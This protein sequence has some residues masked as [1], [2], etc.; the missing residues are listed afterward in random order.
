MHLIPLS[1]AA[2]F[3]VLV[4]VFVALFKKLASRKAAPGIGSDLE[5]LFSVERYKPMDRLLNQTDFQFL[6]SHR[7]Y[8]RRSARRFRSLPP[9]E[10]KPQ[11]RARFLPAKGS[12]KTT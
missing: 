8:D 6:E 9:L 4:V 12:P 3:A 7:A 11:R 5:S 1:T 2:I 10:L